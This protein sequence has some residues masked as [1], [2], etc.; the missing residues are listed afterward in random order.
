MKYTK[1]MFKNNVLYNILQNASILM[2]IDH[3][4]K[5]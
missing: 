4:G 3:N 2:L 5:L 1:Y